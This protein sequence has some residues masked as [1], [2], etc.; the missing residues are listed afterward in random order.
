MLKNKKT[1][2]KISEESTDIYYKNII[3]KY[4]NRNYS[5]YPDVCLADF[6]VNLEHKIYTNKSNSD[7]EYN[8]DSEI[9]QRNNLKII[10]FNQYKLQQDQYNYFRE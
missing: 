10:R 7:D 4:E 8:E 5:K 2:K 3:E 9:I 1:F 6:A